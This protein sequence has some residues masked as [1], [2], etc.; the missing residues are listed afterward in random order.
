[1]SLALALYTTLCEVGNALERLRDTYYPASDE[2]LWHTEVL[3]MLDA[4]ID[5]LVE[6]GGLPSD[7]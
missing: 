4:T 2:W 6:S 7:D 3:G 5:L 1:M